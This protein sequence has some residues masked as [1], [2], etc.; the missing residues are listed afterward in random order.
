MSLTTVIAT[1]PAPASPVDGI[2]SNYIAL[3]DKIADIKQVHTT[4]LKPYND[5]LG[6]LEA[7]LLDALQQT[8]TESMRTL[9]GT[10]YKTTHSSVKVKDWATTL[11]FIQDNGAWDLLEARV[12]KT[13]AEALVSDTAQGIPGVDIDRMVRVN[14]RRPD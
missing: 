14:V 5:M 12:N 3:R 11:A 2:V 1:G 8:N 13:A 4:Q 9:A 6:A 7:M 10:F